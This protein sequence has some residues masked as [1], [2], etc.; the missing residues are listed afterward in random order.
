VRQDQ[1]KGIA[2]HGQDP[3]HVVAGQIAG[4]IRLLCLDEFQVTDITDAMILGRLFEALF[5]GGVA[6]LT[7]SNIAPDD[8]Y[9]DGLNRNAFLPSIA[10]L[11]HNMEVFSLDGDLDYRFQ[12]LADSNHYHCPLGPGVDSRVQL[13]WR[14]LTGT[15]AGQPAELTVTGHPLP[16]PQA[17]RRSCRFDFTDLCARPL[18]AADYLAIAEAYQAVFV[19]HVPVMDD[20]MRNEAKRFVLL[21]DTLYD[22]HVRLVISAQTPPQLLYTGKTHRFEFERTVSRLNEM[23]TREYW[24]DQDNVDVNVA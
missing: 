13:Q 10:M 2:P 18:G 11:K 12:H 9:R 14:T 15:D 20:A 6:V 3:V 17:A 21:I 7:T 16:I 23:M 19:E 1:S 5:D 8:L 4:E 22:R 24:S